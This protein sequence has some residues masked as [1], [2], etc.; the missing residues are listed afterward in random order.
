MRP[1]SPQTHFDHASH[2][3]RLVD[4]LEHDLLPR[5]PEFLDWAIVV[6][7]YAA[8]HYTKAALIRDQG[9][10]SP[11]HRGYRDGDGVFQE[12]HND[13]VHRYFPIDVRTA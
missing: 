4:I 13:L 8:L 2:N 5:N 11:H 1:P 12:G 6:T 9:A 10:F 7:F 3:E